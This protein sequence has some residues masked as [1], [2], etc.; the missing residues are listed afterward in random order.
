MAEE[1]ESKGATSNN[2]QEVAETPGQSVSF[3][4]TVAGIKKKFPRVQNVSTGMLSEW[5]NNGGIAEE[6]NE[7]GVK[8]TRK[9]VVFVSFV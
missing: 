3:R 1:T 7:D 8:D 4:M 6:Q 9:L 2:P 5:M